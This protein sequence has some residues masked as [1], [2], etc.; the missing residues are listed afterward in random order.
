M[1]SVAIKITNNAEFRGVEKY[2]LIGGAYWN[3]KTRNEVYNDGKVLY[4]NEQGMKGHRTTDERYPT[5]YFITL[6]QDDL[7]MNMYEGTSAA[8]QSIRRARYMMINSTQFKSVV[9]VSQEAEKFMEYMFSGMMG[10]TGHIT[11]GMQVDLYPLFN[12]NNFAP[13]DYRKNVT[14]ESG[15]KK[16]A[17]LPYIDM[18]EVA[19]IVNTTTKTTVTKLLAAMGTQNT[20]KSSGI[21][22]SDKS[23]KSIT[24]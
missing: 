20:K 19:D 5:H 16:S 7:Q 18:F 14:E 15:K 11:K 13:D 4:F 23:I 21:C 3:G 22:L 10:T 6:S 1:S 24:K 12:R 17:P 2:L 8:E 9:T